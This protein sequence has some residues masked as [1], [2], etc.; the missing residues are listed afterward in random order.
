MVLEATF[1]V[2]IERPVGEVFPYVADFTNVLE[3]L[4]AAVERRKVTD[5]PVGVG[6]RFEGTDHMP[7]RSFSFTQE[8]V[9]LEPDRLV[10]T[11]LSAPFNGSYDITFEP[12]GDA[13]KLTAE[14]SARPSGV[15]RILGLLPSA[16]LRRQFERDYRKLKA[17]LEAG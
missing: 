7:G 10:R 1:G 13:T 14:V 8:I 4:P 5:G 15:L 17:H 11:T 12:V 9:A 16:I 6:T 2:T 3:W